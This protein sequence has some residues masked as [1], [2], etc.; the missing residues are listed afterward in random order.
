MLEKMIN[1]LV[2]KNNTHEQVQ[3]SKETNIEIERFEK[4]TPNSS[5]LLPF[6]LCI[7]THKNNRT[8]H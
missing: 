5:P 7:S 3:T 6:F 4:D 8:S 2:P 1:Y